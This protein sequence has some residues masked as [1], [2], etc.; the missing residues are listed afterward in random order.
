MNNQQIQHFRNTRDL[1]RNLGNSQSGAAQSSYEPLEYL[2]EVLNEWLEE[3]ENNNIPPTWDYAFTRITWLEIYDFIN[4]NNIKKQYQIERFLNEKAYAVIKNEAF[5]IGIAYG[6]DYDQDPW[7]NT[8]GAIKRLIKLIAYKSVLRYNE[9]LH[10][11][12]FFNENY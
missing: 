1:L 12:A 4:R 6:M 10:E 2:I 3:E 5:W 7:E 8:Y 11:R 9:I